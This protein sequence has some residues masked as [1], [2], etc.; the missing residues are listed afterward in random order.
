MSIRIIKS[1]DI[2]Q[3]YENG[4]A[5][6][7]M[8]PDTY[9]G[10]TNYKC[11]LKKGHTVSPKK[12][13]DKVVMYCFTRGNGYVT[14]PEWSR[15]IREL[16]FFAP[17][18]DNSDFSITAVE[19]MEFLCLVSEMEECEREN[20]PKWHLRLPWFTRMSECKEYVQD[21]KGPNTRSW[22]VLD[23]KYLGGV[24]MGIVRA[25]GEGTTEKG[26]PSVAQ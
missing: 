25:E 15:D 3:E 11:F 2:P 14:T 23:P 9:P 17:D 8:L 12:Y 18:F 13:A 16:S 20:W 21:C 7:E 10:M 6:S 19:D 4:F 24:L 1:K 5:Q 22:S 26:H